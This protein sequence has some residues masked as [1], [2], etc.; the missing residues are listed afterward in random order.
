ND[1]PVVADQSFEMEETAESGTYVGTVAADDPNTSDTLRYSIISGNT[2]NAFAIDSATGRITVGESGLS[3]AAQDRFELVV[4]VEDDYGLS[5]QATVT[6]AVA[7]V[8][9][10]PYGTSDSYTT[11]Q[12]G[13]LTVTGGVLNNDGDADGD[14]LTAVLVEGPSHGALTLN[15][16]G[17]F[18]YTPDEGFYGAD[19]F[20]YSVDD[21]ETTS[22]PI[23][24]T[25]E[26]AKAEEPQK[27]E[28][29]EEPQEPAETT[30]NEEPSPQP[31]Y[32]PA[33]TPTSGNEPI[34]PNTPAPAAP[35]PEPLGDIDSPLPPAPVEVADD[36]FDD[37]E[38][39]NPSSAIPSDGDGA[40]AGEDSPSENGSGSESEQAVDQQPQEAAGQGVSEARNGEAPEIAPAGSLSE[41]ATADTAPPA[42]N[43]PAPQ[44][45]SD[46]A[47]IVESP[48]LQ[49]AI[50][51][52]ESQM[53]SE[54]ALAQDREAIQVGAVTG[55]SLLLSAG[56]VTWCLRAASLLTS[57]LATTPLW[58]W[59]DPVPILDN[60][61]NKNVLPANRPA[62]GPRDGEDDSEDKL[63]RL[64]D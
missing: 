21:G 59:F 60:W 47:V 55:V 34:A 49:E 10:R 62:A 24:V 46:P 18:T 30:V 19:G 17:S 26:V 52:M 61:S 50:S 32:S 13:A 64:V 41:T 11:S 57:L 45:D 27:P 54:L 31:A 48:A 8:N 53:D 39:T 36:V 15:A 51:R 22:D 63:R 28:E 40:T 33:D 58:R 5:D 16:D 14:A 12:D 25:I 29:P 1:A 35:Q 20:A 37:E 3:S 9:E 56:Y 7:E 23:A 42:Q 6:I 2:G 38:M 44:S 4:Q 43:A